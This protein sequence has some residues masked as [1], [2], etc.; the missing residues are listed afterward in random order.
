MRKIEYAIEEEYDTFY[1]FYL[2]GELIF[3]SVDMPYEDYSGSSV[4]NALKCLERHGVLSLELLS[5]NH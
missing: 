4:V 5:A 2:D 3:E 1:R